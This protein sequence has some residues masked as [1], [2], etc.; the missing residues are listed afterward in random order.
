VNGFF[1][2]ARGMLRASGEI[3]VNHK[4]S[5]PFCQWN[6]EE[7]ASQNSL[8]LA[9]CVDFKKED[10][11]GYKNKRG[12]GSRCDKPFP[13]GECS[14]FK[15]RLSLKTKTSCRG[16]RLLA[17]AVHGRSLQFQEIPVLMQQFSISNNFSYPRAGHLT[18]MEQVSEDL[19]LPFATRRVPHL[20]PAVHGR[21][22]QFLAMP[23][24]MHQCST[25]DNFNHP[26][27]GHLTNM[28][29]I[30]EDFRLPSTAR[31]I[32]HVALAAHGRSQRFQETP[33]EMQQFST[34]INSSHPRAGYSMNVEQVSEDVQLP[35]TISARNE[36]FGM[37]D[38]HLNN[39]TEMF[40]RNMIDSS[41]PFH[42]PRLHFRD[43]AEIPGRTLNGD[44]YVLREFQR[45]SYILWS[46][47]RARLMLADSHRP[48]ASGAQVPQYL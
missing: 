3:H 4:T 16:I 47:Q 33:V 37:I 19:W 7:L 36:C 10:Y 9:E 17:P 26:R 12:D 22:Q 44:T 28:E 40:G 8:T 6:I 11:P 48:N 39:Q 29:Q 43:F 18:N 24:Q 45:R 13:L 41:Y 20:A 2:N 35:L 30:S 23:V 14:T 25:S 15:F 34:S 5:R 32:T 46:M 21:S 42:G 31:R 38:G 27:A 1:R